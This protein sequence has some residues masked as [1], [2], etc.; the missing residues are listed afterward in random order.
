MPDIEEDGFV[1]VHHSDYVAT[2]GTKR[3]LIEKGIL[4]DQKTP[5]KLNV[6]DGLIEALRGGRQA[7]MDGT[8]VVVSR[9]ACEEA[10]EIL[11]T[12]KGGA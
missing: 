7:D 6:P 11:A 12:L 2:Q 10:A 1:T 9:Q 3:E 5:S 8:M 4:S